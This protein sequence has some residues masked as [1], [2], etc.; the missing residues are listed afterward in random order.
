MQALKM[1]ALV[2]I[3]HCSA[4]LKKKIYDVSPNNWGV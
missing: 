4:L 2:S 3:G 1:G